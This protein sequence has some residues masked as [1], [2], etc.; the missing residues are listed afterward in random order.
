M[1]ITRAQRGCSA[2]ARTPR[3]APAAPT[4]C[5]TGE[6]GTMQ[7]VDVHGMGRAMQQRFLRVG[8]GDSQAALLYA[9]GGVTHAALW[10]GR[11]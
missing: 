2:P 6:D 1:T 10:A 11:G 9:W 8:L 4:P 3:A 7:R 5:R